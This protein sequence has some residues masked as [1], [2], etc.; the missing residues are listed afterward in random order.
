MPDSITFQS[1]AKVNYTLD[2]LSRRPDGFH[3]IASVMQA[4]TLADSIVL[5]RTD[6]GITMDCDSGEV[7]ADSTNL[8]WRAAE[9]VLKRAGSR[10]GLRITIRKRIPTEAGLGG[11]SS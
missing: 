4:I 2:V 11:G 8:A 7:P 3:N 5:E 9:S 10:A 6:S 1:Y